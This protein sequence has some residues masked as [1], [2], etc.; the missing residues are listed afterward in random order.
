M[1]RL[2][3]AIY[4][5]S[6]FRDDF[7]TYLVNY[8]V[9]TVKQYCSIVKNLIPTPDVCK[10]STTSRVVWL[11]KEV[12][13]WAHYW[14]LSYSIIY[15]ILPSKRVIESPNLAH[16]LEHLHLFPYMLLSPMLW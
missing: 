15:A 5:I 10:W 6:C 8:L 4:N 13:P 2:Q 12:C 3:S 14:N 16:F 7:S 11:E 1:V 9:Y